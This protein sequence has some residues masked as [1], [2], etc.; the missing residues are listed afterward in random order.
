MQSAP[1]PGHPRSLGEPLLL[2]MRFVVL[3]F[4]SVEFQS[5]SGYW[6]TLE[7]VYKML[8]F[9]KKPKHILRTCVLCA[10][11]ALVWILWQNREYMRAVL[12]Q[13]S[14]CL[15]VECGFVLRQSAI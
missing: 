13:K 5:F 10:H 9:S 12:S 1:L 11:I 15:A 7:L 3:T 4:R 2:A 6:E 14:L 8:V